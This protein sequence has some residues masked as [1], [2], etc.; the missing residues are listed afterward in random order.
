MEELLVII[1]Y[2]ASIQDSGTKR[3]N[4]PEGVDGAED[5][6]PVNVSSTMLFTLWNTRLKEFQMSP[7][8]RSGKR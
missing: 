7:E 8:P 1:V 2:E 5:C 3:E 4:A 6:Y